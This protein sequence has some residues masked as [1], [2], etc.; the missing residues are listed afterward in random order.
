MSKCIG[1]TG[2]NSCCKVCEKTVFKKDVLMCQNLEVRNVV[3]ADN[4]VVAGYGIN[5]RNI[6]LPGTDI[7]LIKNLV[8]ETNV[9]SSAL[10]VIGTSEFNNLPI[11]TP[12]K[13]ACTR[14][15]VQKPPS[16]PNVHAWI[17]YRDE[18]LAAVILA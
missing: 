17:M 11:S 9:V 1:C 6:P 2:C 7:S 5:S 4:R 18:G 14:S 16:K 12:D 8:S 10:S 3:Y 13:N 15:L